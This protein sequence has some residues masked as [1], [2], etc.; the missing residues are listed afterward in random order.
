MPAPPPLPG[1]CRHHR[2]CR[3]PKRDGR[4]D[5]TWHPI[6][7]HAKALAA[8]RRWNDARERGINKALG[9]MAR[10]FTHRRD[11]GDRN[12]RAPC[13]SDVAA[14]PGARR[15]SRAS[16]CARIACARTGS[17]QLPPW[18]GSC[19]PPATTRPDYPADGALA[20]RTR[21][22]GHCISDCAQTPHCRPDAISQHRIAQAGG[23]GRP[24]CRARSG[25]LKRAGA[26]K[27]AIGRTP[28]S[29]PH[30]MASAWRSRAVG[31]GR[32][33]TERLDANVAA[34][35]IGG[36][37]S[38]RIPTSAPIALPIRPSR[39]LYISTAVSRPS[40]SAAPRYDESQ[41]FPRGE[42]WGEGEREVVR[43]SFGRRPGAEVAPSPRLGKRRAEG[44]R[45][46]P[47]YSITRPTTRSRPISRSMRRLEAKVRHRT[48][49]TA[50]A[51]RAAAVSWRGA[52]GCRPPLCAREGGSRTDPRFREG[53]RRSAMQLITSG[54]TEALNG[55]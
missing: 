49:P 4:R 40:A 5:G 7:P 18:R 47:I 52:C 41:P 48:A 32:W 33:T 51:A 27:A 44:R 26:T 38:P 39:S 46:S 55:R 14:P 12:L 50:S 43:V 23:R 42:G 29:P 53:A 21:A 1:A 3:R 25:A 19:H 22:Q 54:A 28:T 17:R 6:S 13:P 24:A 2:S 9:G 31:S 30:R 36:R 8:G 37:A 45:M 20:A 10:I 35:P 34:G 11:R 16:G 15:R